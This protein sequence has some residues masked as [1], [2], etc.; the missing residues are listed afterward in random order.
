M[1][2]FEG[3]TGPY[4]QFAHARL[5][6]MER[7]AADE[8]IFINTEADVSTLIEKE[9]ADLFTV[10]GKFPSIV[11]SALQSMEPCTLVNYLMTLSH[12]ISGKFIKMCESKE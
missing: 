10:I 7:K 9:C 8:G 1:T 11:Q 4:L 6:S 3:D 2:S 12:A 5:C